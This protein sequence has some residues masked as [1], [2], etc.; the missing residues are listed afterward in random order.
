MPTYATVIR[1]KNSQACAAIFILS[2]KS[3]LNTKTCTR[4]QLKNN[5]SQVYL[6]SKAMQQQK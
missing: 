3:N 2:Q 6:H 1:V 4:E 5:P